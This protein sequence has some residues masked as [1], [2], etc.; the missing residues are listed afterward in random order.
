MNVLIIED[1]ADICLLYTIWL[2]E[3]NYHYVIARNVEEG[4][5]EYHKSLQNDPKNLNNFDLIILDYD[6]S[7]KNDS[8]MLAKNGLNVA[9][10]I[11]SLNKNQRI[12]F[13]SAWPQRIFN[14]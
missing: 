6:L 11:L 9:K 8:F 4:L 14:E 12:I 10:E 5:Y 3:Y 1:D 2:R 7:P 13:A